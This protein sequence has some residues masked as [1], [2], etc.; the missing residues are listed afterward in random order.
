MRQTPRRGF[1][2]AA[3]DTAESAEVVVLPTVAVANLLARTPGHSASIEIGSFLVLR[4][5]SMGMKKCWNY[6]LGRRKDL[7]GMYVI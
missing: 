5:R 3:A 7:G 1:S 2:E 4:R 6:V